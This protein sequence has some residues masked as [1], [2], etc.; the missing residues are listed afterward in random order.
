M[1]ELLSIASDTT[2][3]S[4]TANECRLDW[5][6]MILRSRTRDQRFFVYGESE[7]SADN[8]SR[9]ALKCLVGVA[10]NAVT[11]GWR[12][13]PVCLIT[14]FDVSEIIELDATRPVPSSRFP[15]DNFSGP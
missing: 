11:A 1:I 6:T 14:T 12:C 8:T 2:K 5:I 3:I 4:Y 7:L 9:V 13:S 10:V 15:T